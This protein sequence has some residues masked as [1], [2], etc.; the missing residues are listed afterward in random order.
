MS[1]KVNRNRKGFTLIELI[2]VVVLLGVLAA[3]ALPRFIDINEQAHHASISAVGSAYA[4]A[5]ALTHAQWIANGFRKGDPIDDL[6]GYGNSNVNM[7]ADGWPTGITGPD[8]S[9]NLEPSKCTEL[10]S[11]L[12]ESNAPKISE[13]SEKADYLISVA[14]DINGFP[15][16][17]CVYTY[18]KDNS[19]SNIRYDA[20]MGMVTT[21]LN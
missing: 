19:N 12:L 1:G 11:S 2:I 14:E 9:P 8:S 20:D 13:T 7:S 17:D 5:V 16:K 10:W 4:A 15:G 6:V 21:T 3:T 18:Q